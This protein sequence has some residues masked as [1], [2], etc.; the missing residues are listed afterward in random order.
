MKS[1]DLP[2]PPDP[3]PDPPPLDPDSNL[4]EPVPPD[5]SD[6]GSCKSSNSS[7]DDL[8]VHELSL[9][10]SDPSLRVSSETGS[11]R[12]LVDSSHEVIEA[13]RDVRLELETANTSILE[14]SNSEAIGPNRTLPPEVAFSFD[15]VDSKIIDFRPPLL[16]AR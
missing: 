1:L 8:N 7:A 16:M 10:L 14:L 13:I 2:D 4:S 12:D 9:S 6:T 11:S 15:E 5:L 3:D